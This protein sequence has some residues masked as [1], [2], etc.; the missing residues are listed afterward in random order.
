MKINGENNALIKSTFALALPAIADMFIQMLFGIIDMSMA[1][2]LGSFAIAAI[3][4]AETPLMTSMAIFSAASVGAT[5]LVAREIG[6]KNPEEASKISAQAIFINIVLALIVTLIMVPLSRN[7]IILMGAQENTVIPAT[8]YLSTTSLSL[9]FIGI[10]FVI[11][12]ILRGAGNTKTP[13][14]INAFSLI[15]NLILNFLFIFPSRTLWLTLPLLGSFTLP[16]VGFGLGIQGAALGTLLSRMISGIILMTLIA[17]NRVSISIH[18]KS[19]FK[20]QLK[21]IR[22]IL[23][24]GIPAAIEQLIMRSGQLL[25]TRA[26]ASLGTV[27]LA[28]HRITIVSES[29]SFYVGFGFAL[30][31]TTLVGQY[32]GAKEPDKASKSGHIA[33]LM[34]ILFM[35]F[36]GI[37][38]F[39]FPEAIIKIFNSEPE[40]LK[41]AV[42]CLRIVAFSQ[43]F[44]AAAMA[45]AGALRGAG[46][47]TGVLVITFI[48]IWG[49]RLLGTLW[50]IQMGFGLFGAWIAM[51]LDQFGRSLLLFSRFKRGRWKDIQV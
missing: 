20:P 4:L 23:Q 25:Y 3:G 8:K 24:I 10:N 36:M 14:K 12:G 6:A 35:S 49:L 43:P 40:I 5:A 33:S 51:C 1:G 18:L 37:F 47:T 9:F 2:R 11:A 41:L 16:M 30:S 17:G 42:P 50:A 13:M 22:R 38:F 46:D 15:L 34:G 21:I 7:I 31:G 39:F 19:I 45:Y 26:I 28:A 27:V 32:L 48:G 29:L 44:L